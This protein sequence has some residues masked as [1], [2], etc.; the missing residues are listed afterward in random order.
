MAK[1][2]AVSGKR[3][4]SGNNVSHANN[5]T[6]KKWN[7]NLHKKRLFDSESGQWVTLRVSSRILRT[8]DKKGLSATLKEMGKSVSDFR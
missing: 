7:V 8:I 6:R 1:R 4:Q 2:C 5:K 3:A